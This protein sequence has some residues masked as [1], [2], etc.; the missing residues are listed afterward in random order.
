MVSTI[1]TLFKDDIAELKQ[2]AGTNHPSNITSRWTIR[3][4]I[5][6]AFGS[7]FD[8]KWMIAAYTELTST[9]ES[10]VTYQTLLGDSNLR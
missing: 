3:A 7:A 2:E 5:S 1:N 10:F 4:I 6:V 8:H 9:I